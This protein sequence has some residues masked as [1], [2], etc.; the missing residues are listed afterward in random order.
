MC[1]GV[2]GR[3]VTTNRGLFFGE[4]PEAAPLGLDDDPPL[5]RPLAGGIPGLAVQMLGLAGGLGPHPR[6]AHQPLRALL[7]PGVAAERDHILDARGLQEGQ[8]VVA[9]EAAIQPHAQPRAR[10]GRAEFADQVPQAPMAPH[11]AGLVPGRSKART[12]YCAA[13]SSKLTNPKS[14][15]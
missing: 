9:G 11:L 8:H 2:C 12:R 7:H 15:R 4:R 10:K 3:L 14:G 13:S 5:A 1:C 6:L